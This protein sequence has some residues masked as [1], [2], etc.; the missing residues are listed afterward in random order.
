MLWALLPVLMLWSAEPVLANFPPPPW[1]DK[2]YIEHSFYDI[3]LQGEY[4]SEHVIPVVKRWVRPLRVWMYSGAGNAME[5]RHLLQTHLERL[6]GI[7]RL[8]VQ[9]VER[10]RDANVRVFFAA[11]R[12]LKSLTSREMTTTAY[13]ELKRSV[14]IGTIRF[15]RR[16]E[17]TRGT[18]LIP[19]ERAQALGKLDSCVIEEVTQMLGLIN[20]SRTARHTVFSDVTENDQLTGLDYLLIKLLYSPYLR[21]GMNAREAAPLVRHQLELWEMTG[22]IRQADRLAYTGL[23]LAGG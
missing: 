15:N 19:V 7:I 23:R 22:A 2:Q 11:D 20:D 4:R 1:L 18:V 16:S 13:R 12:E 14:C 5:Q 3:A 17:I 6:A 9:F 10:S 8:P 21:N